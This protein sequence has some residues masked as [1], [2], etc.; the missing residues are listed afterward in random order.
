MTFQN[1]KELKAVAPSGEPGGV[2]VRVDTGNDIVGVLHDGYT[3]E[4]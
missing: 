2:D 3:Y 1:D 4:S